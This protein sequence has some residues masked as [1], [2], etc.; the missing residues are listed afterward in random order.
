MTLTQ[1]ALNLSWEGKMQQTQAQ[2]F[3]EEEGLSLVDVCSDA[4]LMGSD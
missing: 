1:R 4:A 3:V 2:K